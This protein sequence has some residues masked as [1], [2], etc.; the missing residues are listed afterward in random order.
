MLLKYSHI[1]ELYRILYL[2]IEV[3]IIVKILYT[4]KSNDLVK[5]LL[6]IDIHKNIRSQ[7]K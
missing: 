7:N 2:F 1:L 3:Y 5:G 4:I 6:D